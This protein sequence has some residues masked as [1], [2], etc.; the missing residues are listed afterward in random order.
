[1]ARAKRTERAEV[2]RRYR[3]TL[4]AETAGADV[5]PDATIPAAARTPA[6][7]APAAPPAATT[8]AQRPT[9]LSSL[10]GAVGPA[11]VRGDLAALPFLATRTKAI[12]VPLLAAVATAVVAFAAGA[13][14]NIVV[15]LLFQAFLVPPPMAASFLGGILAPR[16]SWLVGGIVGLAAGILFSI[17]IVAAPDATLYGLFRADPSVPVPQDFRAQYVAQAL[18]LSPLLGLVVGAFAGFYRRFLRV[19]NPNSQRRQARAGGRR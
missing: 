16:A 9:L 7:R 2:R 10:R 11:D 17:V 8:P 12:W 18:V 19:M 3:Q 14:G 5:T 6:T 15:V 1:V 4:A 13:Q